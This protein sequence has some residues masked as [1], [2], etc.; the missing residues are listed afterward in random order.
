MDGGQGVCVR[1]FF[2]EVARAEK[3]GRPFVMATVVES[4]GSTPRT[5]GARML[6]EA[7][8]TVGT[9]GGGA[10]EHHVIDQARTLLDG[11]GPTTQMITVHLVRDLGMCCGG[12]MK[13][14]L[15]KTDPR[16]RLWIFGAGHVGTELATVAHVAGFDVAVVDE[17]AEWAAAERFLDG[18]EV[19]DEDPIDFI[20]ST[21][22]AETDFV[23]IM[24]HS[25]PVDEAVLRALADR[26]LRYLGMI[27]S[28]G[29]WA[30]F[31]N[32]LSAR[33]LDAERI[34]RVHCPVGLDIAALTPGEIAIAV[35]AQLIS[36]RRGGPKWTSVSTPEVSLTVDTEE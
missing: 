34:D 32:R 25:H 33:G 1:T 23:V 24:T 28:R 16:P 36:V 26:P 8:R 30:R 14:F 27:G 17:R 3:A 2:A 15:E 11:R 35:A 19:N 20:K 12:K 13:V 6:V 29:K 9:I 7:D 4:G 21:P 18:I 31:R 22:P 5:A 10:L